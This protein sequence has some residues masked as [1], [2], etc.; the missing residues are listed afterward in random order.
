MED[1]R[2]EETTKDK[3]SL[4]AIYIA[5]ELEKIKDQKSKALLKLKVQQLIFEA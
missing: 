2:C 1:K 5:K 3:D 4:F